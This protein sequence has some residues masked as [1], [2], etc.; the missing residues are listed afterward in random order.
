MHTPL[1]AAA[2]VAAS[3]LVLTGTSRTATSLGGANVLTYHNDIARTGQNLAETILTPATVSAST[4][5]KV[6]FFAVDGKVDAQP[7][8]LSGVPI[9][10]QGTHNVVY[11]ATE[12]DSV[13]AF[14]LGLRRGALARLGARRGRS[15]QRRPKLLAGRARDRCHVDAGHRPGAWSARRDL[16]GRDVEKRIGDVRSAAARARRRDGR[17]VVRRTEA[18]AGFGTRQPAP[19]AAAAR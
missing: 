3:A 1:K 13:Y 5:G 4:F 16:R 6:G 17:R 12:H 19:A 15:A 14:D 18:R 8:M 9:A 2:F 7:L 11:V 10:G